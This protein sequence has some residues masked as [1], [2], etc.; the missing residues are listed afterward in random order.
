MIPRDSPHEFETNSFSFK[1]FAFDNKAVVTRLSEN[2]PRFVAASISFCYRST[3][4]QKAILLT[5]QL[6]PALFSLLVIICNTKF[7]VEYVPLH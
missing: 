2:S 1:S 3:D 5:H 6:C 7:Q 4:Y